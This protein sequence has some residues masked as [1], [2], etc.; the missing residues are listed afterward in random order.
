MDP[1][2]T[3]VDEDQYNVDAAVRKHCP[4]GAV[5]AIASNVECVFMG[6]SAVM[7][8]DKA[9]A[10]MLE[11]LACREAIALAEDINVQSVRVASDCLNAVRSIQQGTLGAYALIVIVKEINDSILAFDTLEFIHEGRRSNVEA[12]GLARSVVFDE[13]GHRLWLVSPPDSLCIPDI[14]EV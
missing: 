7:I 4:R 5:A 13:P 12:H 3:G 11:I 14:V 9:D 1:A 8:P 10:E 6:G 2:A